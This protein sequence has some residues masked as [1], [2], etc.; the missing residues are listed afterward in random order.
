[1]CWPKCLIAK[2]LCSR[3]NHEDTIRPNTTSRRG[4]WYFFCRL[5]SVCLLPAACLLKAWLP[6]CRDGERRCLEMLN[7]D[8]RRWWA[9]NAICDYRKCRLR[10]VQMPFAYI[11]DAICEPPF[12]NN[13]IQVSRTSTSMFSARRQSPCRNA[14]VCCAKARIR[15]FVT[16]LPCS[17]AIC[18]LPIERKYFYFM[19]SK[20]SL[21]KLFRNFANR[22]HIKY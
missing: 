19:R 4:L 20:R 2:R 17:K 3:N 10:G 14:V 8:V 16:A 15:L 21:F 22:K 1:M 11:A 13:G 18:C 5:R 6:M 7:V 12:S 9:A